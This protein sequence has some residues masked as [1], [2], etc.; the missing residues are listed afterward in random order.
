M[1]EEEL[2][3]T[4]ADLDFARIG[5]TAPAFAEEDASL[6]EGALAAYRAD[7]SLVLVRDSARCHAAHT[8]SSYRR[9]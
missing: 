8:A 2:P 4:D 7:A 3:V 1:A 5:A 9:V 6:R